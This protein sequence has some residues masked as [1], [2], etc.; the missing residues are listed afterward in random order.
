MPRNDTITFMNEAIQLD[1][2]LGEGLPPTGSIKPLSPRAIWA[3]RLG[4]MVALV[5]S[6]CALFWPK[7]S[8]L[9][10]AGMLVDTSGQVVTLGSQLAPV[11]LIH[12]WATWCPPCID[13]VPAI[14]R[15]SDDYANNHQFALVM[16]AVQDDPDA[17]KEFL[18]GRFKYTLFDPQWQVARRYGTEKVP[19]TFLVVDGKVVESFIGATNWDD[20]RARQQIDQALAAVQD[21]G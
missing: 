15:L 12:F 9:E 17:V 2:D 14:R 19:E 8:D 21:R 18:E 20:P 13:E 1:D 10:A 6:L 16:V 11:T 3:A 5:V 7:T 4:T